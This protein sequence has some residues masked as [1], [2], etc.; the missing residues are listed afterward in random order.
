M[1]EGRAQNA[2]WWLVDNLWQVAV[3]AVA[4]YTIV[5]Y[6]RGILTVNDVVVW[7]LAVVELMAISGIIERHRR[8]GGIEKAISELQTQSTVAGICR[9]YEDRTQLPPLLRDLQSTRR[10]LFVVGLALVSLTLTFLDALRERAEQGCKLRVLM[11]CPGHNGQVNPVIRE[12]AINLG[13]DPDDYASSIEGSLG[14]LLSMKASLP[15]EKQKNVEIKV[16]DCVP[17][18]VMMAFDGNTRTGRV[19]FD[20]IPYKVSRSLWPTIELRHDERSKIY[21]F[22]YQSANQLWQDAHYWTP[23]SRQPL[24]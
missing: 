18:F 21:E 11:I 15:E 7:L 5:Q 2:F 24:Q 16:Y 10:E 8:I 20:L 22:F 4:T 3:V 6:E 9:L 13:F 23:E 19:R 17:T 12:I 1:N 14:R